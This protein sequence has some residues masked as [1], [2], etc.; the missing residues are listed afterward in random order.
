MVGRSIIKGLVVVALTSQ[1]AFGASYYEAAVNNVKV[2]GSVVK[3]AVVNGA[4]KGY[5]A[6]KDSVVYVG[7]VIAAHAA[8]A[9]KVVAAKAHNGYN[10]ACKATGHITEGFTKAGMTLYGGVAGYWVNHRDACIVGLTLTGAAA[11]IAAYKYYKARK[12]QR[13]IDELR[14]HQA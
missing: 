8:P 3:A 14:R 11:T 4:V 7:Q 13:Q 2:A 12:T 10:V 9:G 6:S 1:M 5:N